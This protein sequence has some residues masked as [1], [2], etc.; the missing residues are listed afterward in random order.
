MCGGRLQ[1][2]EVSLYFILLARVSYN[3]T[4]SRKYKG[5]PGQALTFAFAGGCWTGKTCMEYQG[6][7]EVGVIC[8]RSANVYLKCMYVQGRYYS[9]GILSTCFCFPCLADKRAE[10]LE[11]IDNE[12]QVTRT[13]LFFF[14]VV[15]LIVGKG[16][17]GVFM[18][19]ICTCVQTVMMLQICRVRVGKLDIF[20]MVILP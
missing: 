5:S 2:E 8:L 12:M 19:S 4:P 11:P 14:S 16:P 9:G 18:Q 3:E 7:V 17:R 10:A 13:L 6:V 15:G 1:V 20:R